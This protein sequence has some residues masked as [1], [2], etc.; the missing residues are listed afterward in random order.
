MAR[1]P[2][3]S[4]PNDQEWACIVPHVE[5]KGGPGRKRTVDIREVINVLC[6]MSKTGVNGACSPMTCSPG[7]TLPT[8]ITNGLSMAH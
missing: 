5:L 1:L 3:A 7:N 4:D 2:Y 6:Y 8:I